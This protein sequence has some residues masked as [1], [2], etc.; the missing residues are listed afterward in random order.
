MVNCNY[1]FDSMAIVYT[2]PIRLLIRRQKE[3][4][5]HFQFL[6]YACGM[7]SKFTVSLQRLRSAFLLTLF[8]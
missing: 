8:L 2:N 4:I 7:N 6:T 5:I 3:E 1:D